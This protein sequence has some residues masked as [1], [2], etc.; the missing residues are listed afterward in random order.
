MTKISLFYIKHFLLLT[1][2]YTQEQK[3]MSNYSVPLVSNNSTKSVPQ[4]TK[5]QHVKLLAQQISPEFHFTDCKPPFD[6]PHPQKQFHPQHLMEFIVPMEYYTQN[7][8]GFGQFD[9]KVHHN[10]IKHCSVIM[11]IMCWIGKTAREDIVAAN[12]GESVATVNSHV[13][14]TFTRLPKDPSHFSEKD[15]ENHQPGLKKIDWTH[16]TAEEIDSLCHETAAFIFRLTLDGFN[17]NGNLTTIASYVVRLQGEIEQLKRDRAKG[18]KKLDTIYLGPE[19][20][21][22]TSEQLF[23]TIKLF[24]SIKH[25]LDVAQAFENP[26][27]PFNPSVAFQPFRQ[28]GTVG[29]KCGTVK[30]MLDIRNWINMGQDAATGK[31]VVTGYKFPYD[32]YFTYRVNAY[33]MDPKL[34]RRFTFPWVQNIQVHSPEEVNHFAR[35]YSQPSNLPTCIPVGIPTAD[36]LERLLSQQED[37]EEGGYDSDD[38]HAVDEQKAAAQTFEQFGARHVRFN[39]D[40]TIDL[41]KVRV[42]Q[43][44]DE[45]KRNFIRGTKDYSN[46]MLAVRK[47]LLHDFHTHLWH[48]NAAVS[49][50]LRAIAGW[51]NAHLQQFS[52]FS[53][54]SKRLFKNLSPI[55]CAVVEFLAQMEAIFL[56]KFTHL[57][58]LILFLSA[59]QVYTGTQFHCHCLLLGPAMGG[60]TFLLELLKRILIDET[61]SWLSYRTMK[62]KTAQTEGAIYKKNDQIEL[63]E[64]VDPGMLGIT[65]D[66]SQAGNSNTTDEALMKGWLTSGIIAFQVLAII[67]GVRQTVEAE[68]QCNSVFIAA[69]NPSKSELS[70]PMKS[71]FCV[72]DIQLREREDEGVT[73]MRTLK[74]PTDMQRKAIEALKFKLRRDQAMY[75]YIAKLQYVGILPE[76]DL[77]APLYIVMGTLKYARD[78]NILLQDTTENRHFQRVKFLLQSCTLWGI[79]RLFFDSE[80]SPVKDKEY[81]FNDILKII[82]LLYSSKEHASIVLRMLAHQYDDEVQKNVIIHLSKF[83]VEY[84]IAELLELGRAEVEAE[85]QEMNPARP[86]ERKKNVWKATPQEQ[87]RRDPV[88]GDHRIGPLSNEDI[89]QR[90]EARYHKAMELSSR[91]YISAYVPGSHLYNRIN[92]TN[93]I[94][95]QCFTRHIK[96]TMNPRPNEYDVQAALRYLSDTQDRKGEPVVS[97]EFTENAGD[98]SVIQ[99]LTETVKEFADPRV[100][101][102]DSLLFHCLKQVMNHRYADGGTVCLYGPSDTSFFIAEVFTIEPSEDTMIDLPN[103]SYFSELVQKINVA[104][105]EGLYDKYRGEKP[106]CQWYDMFSNHEKIRFENDLDT[107][108]VEVFNEKHGLTDDELRCHGVL[109]S[110]HPK[111][112]LELIQIRYSDEQWGR[113]LDYSTNLFRENERRR[114][115]SIL[116]S[117]V[118]IEEI[119]RKRYRIAEEEN[120]AHI[121]QQEQVYADRG[122]LAIHFSQPNTEMSNDEEGTEMSDQE[123]AEEGVSSMQI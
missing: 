104:G 28:F 105:F 23:N 43:R 80:I 11:E 19:L 24:T 112:I 16:K 116:S 120:K 70:L 75:A 115:V 61:F 50:S 46:A 4:L 77:T 34:F 18:K 27:N 51:W 90:Y 69:G 29:L 6:Y 123:E 92:L 78:H 12:K 57:T 47:E 86:R 91:R 106:K 121:Q 81:E 17:V 3:E 83:V 107:F 36:D 52:G 49:D 37:P 122:N 54:P 62:S 32:G 71:R 118:Q 102:R 41:F 22:L 99:V 82:P 55:A 39:A 84:D 35:I 63:M 38:T 20:D 45:V 15:K 44:L 59:L 40:I 95:I 111:S 65:K 119:R 8:R 72:I 1:S 97:F 88:H 103:P 96:N 53:M 74:E 73:A 113:F 14:V 98:D 85:E 109:P 100:N 26:R 110:N 9:F 108:A 58:A 25:G 33:D 42:N 67:E 93:E 2:I 7:A 30:N 48:P 66:R 10:M 101:N 117:R 64:E 31:P 94:L 5:L 13:Y 68:I 21:S 60:K 56:V 114:N 79:I 89:K 76:I 87:W